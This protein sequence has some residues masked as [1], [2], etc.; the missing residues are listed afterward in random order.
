MGGAGI[1][2]PKH[3]DLMAGIT[4]L[5]ELQDKMIRQVCMYF[6]IVL[7]KACWASLVNLS[8][9]NSTTTKKCENVQI[10][11]PQAWSI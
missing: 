9:S 2:I 5:V 1:L 6:S 10:T 3:R 11:P 7:R 4:L 8:T